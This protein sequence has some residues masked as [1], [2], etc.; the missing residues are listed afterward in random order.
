MVKPLRR[1]ESRDRKVGKMMVETR[2]RT[3]EAD[4]DLKF[5][6]L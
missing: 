5:P 6:S 1:G 3:A 2:R 4:P